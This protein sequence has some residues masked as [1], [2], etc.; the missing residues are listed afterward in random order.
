MAGAFWLGLGFVARADVGPP[1][2]CPDGTHHEY[3]YGHRC[4]RDGFHLE[5]KEG[6]AV[7][8]Q[9]LPPGHVTLRVEPDTLGSERDFARPRSAF[10]VC[11]REA[12]RARPDLRG[13][14]TVSLSLV[15]GHFRPPDPPPELLGEPTLWPCVWERLRAASLATPATGPVTLHLDFQPGPGGD[16]A[17][18]PA[19]AAPP[20]EASPPAAP[21]GWCATA[22]GAL[23][24]A[25]PLLAGG[26]LVAR[27]RARA[28]DRS[29]GPGAAEGGQAGAGADR[30]RP[31]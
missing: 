7:E 28:T 20:V 9:D 30:S 5:E 23:P 1:P 17:A 27:R 8:V 24:V 2:T 25:A 16:P 15:G 21:P 29:G 11:Y 19:P 26:L 14:A 6:H 4:V 18:P 10:S 12:L 13:A 3:R 22:P 31:T